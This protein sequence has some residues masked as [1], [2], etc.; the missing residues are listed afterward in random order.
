MDGSE[1]MLCLDGFHLV[2]LLCPSGPEVCGWVLTVSCGV[3]INLGSPI[4]QVRKLRPRTAEDVR[5][6]RSHG[7]EAFELVSSCSLGTQ[8]S[9]GYSRGNC[10]QPH[11]CETSERDKPS[12]HL[13][14]SACVR[15]VPGQ[16]AGARV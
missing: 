14:G 11:N 2:A 16:E 10:R 9:V 12:A 3:H 4:V 15:P 1:A 6:P 13:C 5:C 7:S 8:G